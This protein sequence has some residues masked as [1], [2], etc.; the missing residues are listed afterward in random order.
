MGEY[1]GEVGEYAG[2][3]GLYEGDVGEY[4]GDLEPKPGLVGEYD[5]ENVGNPAGHGPA[6]GPG[7]NCAANGDAPSPGEK[8]LWAGEVPGEKGIE[9][10][11]KGVR[12]LSPPPGVA[13]TSTRASPK[14]SKTVAATVSVGCASLSISSFK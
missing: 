2:E 1:D 6:P 10:S 11:P 12:L 4:A 5:G 7:E 8:M 3:V 9:P 14:S 13:V